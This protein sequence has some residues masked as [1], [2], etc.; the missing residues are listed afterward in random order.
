[1][2]NAGMLVESS[3]DGQR[4]V[5]ALKATRL[6][7]IAVR[8][9]L[10]PSTVASIARWLKPNSDGVP[11]SLTFLNLP[12]V[13]A[14]TRDR[15]PRVPADFEEL[16]Q[17]GAQLGKEHSRLLAGHQDEA[18]LRFGAPGRRLLAI[19]KTALIV[20]EWT[21]EGNVDSV[22]ERFGCYAFEVRRLGECFTRL[23]TAAIAVATP[24]KD[25]R[26][27]TSSNAVSELW[28]EEPPL[29]ERVKALSAMVAHGLDELTVTLTYIQ[30]IGAITARRLRDVG[31]TDIE[32][33]ALVD[34]ADDL[35]IRSRL[36]RPSGAVDQRS[37][38]HDS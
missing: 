35:R 16:E 21:R 4:A 30:G 9:M 19:R 10:A 31:V 23:L 13:C 37:R 36:A 17:L 28:D 34:S 29:L 5:P 26:E 25:E 6:G 3:D 7:R 11:T 32:E 18:V 24:E 27:D 8:Q 1:M 20:R 38:P 33:L 15:E 2:V 14:A 12:L 22:A